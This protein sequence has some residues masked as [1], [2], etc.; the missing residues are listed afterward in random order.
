MRHGPWQLEWCLSLLELGWGCGH[1]SLH[2]LEGAGTDPGTFTHAADELPVIDGAAPERGFSH[3]ML[4]TK[5]PDRLEQCFG[6][7]RTPA[8]FPGSAHTEVSR[9]SQVG[10]P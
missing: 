3:A 6:P 5:L 2:L 7:H 4:T 8:F 10:E 1:E 9:L